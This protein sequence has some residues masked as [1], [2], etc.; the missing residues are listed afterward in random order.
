MVL[1][2]R[3]VPL[4]EPVSKMEA[5]TA[6]QARIVREKYR[7]RSGLGDLFVSMATS[8]EYGGTLA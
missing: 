6:P 3:A 5:Q 7:G 4:F 8:P 1:S 2:G